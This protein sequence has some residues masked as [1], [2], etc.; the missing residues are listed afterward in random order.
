MISNTDT[1]HLS[2]Y[3]G[4]IY[5]SMRYVTLGVTIMMVTL[6]LDTTDYSV[7]AVFATYS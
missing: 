7:T 6:I 2:I 1:D 4:I 3:M 5:R